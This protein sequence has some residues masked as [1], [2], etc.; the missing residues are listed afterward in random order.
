MM[1]FLECG[2]E[3]ILVMGEQFTT[4]PLCG[5]THSTAATMPHKI[6]QVNVIAGGTANCDSRCIYAIGPDCDCSCG[7]ANH[8]RG[9]MGE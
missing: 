7:G 5:V 8:G 1:R 2:C 6:R 4:C 3:N 9:H